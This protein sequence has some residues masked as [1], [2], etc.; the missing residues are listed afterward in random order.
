MTY[1]EVADAVT[2]ANLEEIL[3]EVEHEKSRRSGSE[4]SRPDITRGRNGASNTD[5]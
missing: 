1:K 2:K 5:G 4:R 3:S